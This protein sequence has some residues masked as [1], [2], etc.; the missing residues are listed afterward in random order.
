MPAIQHPDLLVGASTSDDAAVFRLSPDLCLVQTVDFFPPIVDDPYDYGA[1][2]AAN[3][4]S[5]IYAMGAHPLLAMNLVCF[6]DDLPK[7]VLGRV[8]RGGADVAQEAGVLIVG[9]HTIVDKEPKY[10][11]AA[12]GIVRPEEFVTNAGA[13]PGD[14]LVLTKPIGTGIITTAGKAGKA[15]E[16]VLSAAVAHMRTL[17]RASSEAMA[18]VGANACTDVT[19]FGLIGHLRSMMEASGV[20]GHLRYGAVPLMEGAQELLEEGFVPGGTRRNWES[21]SKLVRWEPEVSEEA[22]FLLCDAQTSGGLLISLPEERVP[23]LLEELSS[24]ETMGAVI[25]HV[26]P[27]EGIAVTVQP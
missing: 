10:G 8:L 4:L 7:D 26:A 20:T 3:S 24:R 9:G 21:L 27:S 2:S 13:K 16:G 12:T 19:G 25:G 22:Q 23:R 5:D 6:P 11:L 17:N 1:I 18:A 14:V 15:P